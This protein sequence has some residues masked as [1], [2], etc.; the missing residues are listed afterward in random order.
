M[1]RIFDDAEDARYRDMQRDIER[2]IPQSGG[3]LSD[4][5]ERRI[6]ERL[7]RNSSF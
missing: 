6:A 4:E 5:I 2:F 1:R 3:P 7:T